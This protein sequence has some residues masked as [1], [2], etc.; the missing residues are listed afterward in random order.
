MKRIF[1]YLHLYRIAIAGEL[2]IKITGTVAELLLP[3]ML[4]V[5]LD[6]YVPLGRLDI[7][8]QWGGLMVLCAVAALVCNIVANRMSTRISREVTRQLRY[9]L[10]DRV[11]NLSAAQV[12]RLTIPSLISRLTS[13]TYHVHQ[14]V[15]RMQR[16]AV[17]APIMLL[18]GV[19]LT[20]FLEPVLACVLVLP[21]PLMVGGV[22]LLSQKGIRLYTQT[23]TAVDQLVRRAKESMAGIRVIQALSK[24]EYENRQFD[25]ANT[26]AADSEFHAGLLMNATNPIMS[27][28]LN[29]GLT[30]VVVAGAFRVNAG[31]TQPGAVIAFLS[32]FT[33]ILNALMMVSRI[34]IMFSKG[35]ASGRR[36]AEVLEMPEDMGN[37]FSAAETN[38][39]H[40]QFRGVS[41]SYGKNEEDLRDVSFSLEQGQTLGIIG[42]TGSG[43]TTLVRLLMRLYDP[44]AGQI[45]IHGRD[46]RS[47]PREI[48]YTM[49]GAA[50]QSDF[51]FAGTLED[52]IDFGRG[53][54]PEDIGRGAALAQAEFIAS[55]PGG[56]EGSIASRGT[57]L[58]GG[59]KQR[60]LLARA[61]AG[62]PEIL[63]LDDSSSALDYKTD[64]ALR[65]ALNRELAG[66]TKVIV[67]QRVS[68][69][70]HADCILMMEEGRVVGCGSHEQLMECC[71]DYEAIARI[72]MGEVEE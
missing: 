44:D 7:I 12:D 55:R 17:R 4:S 31:A 66:V 13:D 47:I 11:L 9:D 14:M 43:K 28:L 26:Q 32:Y 35:I 1:A 52:N 62:S 5:I 25:A 45:L 69:I 40:I 2:T 36:I 71:P 42:P 46:L 48:L 33:M 58:S 16:L 64:A 68:A 53:L 67:A 21:L 30:A 24:S 39:P 38:A 56:M 10:F 51:L 65:R 34:F 49:F 70:R 59:Q 57:D 50:L 54:K 23:Q 63:I 19:A 22:W 15:D 6:R 8:L 29:T 61:L 60:V 37:V 18:G 20:F 41:F 72:Q 3:W 27:A